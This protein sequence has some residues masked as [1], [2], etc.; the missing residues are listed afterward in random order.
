M[1]E[2]KDEGRGKTN[3]AERETE[4]TARNTKNKKKHVFRINAASNQPSRRKK[5]NCAN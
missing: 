3:K 1:P 4:V 5:V 2:R